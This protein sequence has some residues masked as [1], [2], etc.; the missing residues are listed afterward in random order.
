MKRAAL[1]A[2]LIAYAWVTSG[3]APFSAPSYFLVGIPCLVFVVICGLLG[4]LSNG[5]AAIS[6]DIRSRS[7]D[8]TLSTVAPWI[9][10][11]AAVIVLEAIGL[12][13]GGRS[14]NVPTLSTTVDHLLSVR[15]ERCLICLA[16]LLAGAFQLKQLRRIRD[17]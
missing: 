3:V 17:S 5:R 6:A 7:G 15:W 16:W 13:L 2:V 9:A 1:V 10:L 4:G 8:S 14:A 11:M 12:L